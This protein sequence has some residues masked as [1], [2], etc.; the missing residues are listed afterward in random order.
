[1]TDYLKDEIDYDDPSIASGIDELSLWSSRF[2]LLLFR[3]LEFQRNLEIL[4]LGCGTGFPLLELANTYGRSCRLVGIDI[5]EQALRRAACKLRMHRGR[6]VELVLG[7]GA[8]MP[9]GSSRFDLIVSNLGIN[10]FEDPETTL[11][12]CARVAKVGGR[13]ILTT[14]T[15][16]HL[17]EFYDIFRRVLQASGADYVTRFEENEDH[18]ATPESLRALIET[19]GFEVVRTVKDEFELRYQDSDAFFRHPLTRLGFLDG[20]RAVLDPEEELEIFS[21]LEQKLDELAAEKGELRMTVPMLLVECV[22][23]GIGSP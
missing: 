14:N 19:C 10:N 23:S 13:L 7:D 2:G 1:M 3:H 12:E 16:G 22:A 18:R 6:N 17:K 15:K 20:W 4:D 21:T 9:F 5:W 11:L 8:H